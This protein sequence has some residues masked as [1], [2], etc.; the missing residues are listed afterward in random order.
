LWVALGFFCCALIAF[1]AAVQVGH[2]HL[3]SQGA[4]SDCALCHTAHIVVQ[5]PIPQTLPQ[6]VRTVAA[7]STAPQ[8][9]RVHVFCVFS[10]FTRPP[11]V[12]VAFA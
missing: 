3:D 10:L 6:T 1:T 2:T 8:P 7:I 9:I 5:P 12:D 4:Q 11:P